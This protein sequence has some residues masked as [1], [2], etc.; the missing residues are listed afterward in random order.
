VDDS[1][2]KGWRRRCARLARATLTITAATATSAAEEVDV[3][4]LSLLHDMDAQKYA[5]ARSRVGGDDAAALEAELL[6]Y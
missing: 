4:D 2:S 1:G 3:L 6:D 5:R